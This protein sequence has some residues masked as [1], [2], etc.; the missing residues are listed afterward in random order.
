[1]AR[2][3]VR[4]AAGSLG[5]VV[6]RPD[7]LYRAWEPFTLARFFK[8]YEVELVLDIGAN[9][10]QY[11]TMIRERA[12]Y[13]GRIVSCEPNPQ[14]SD[15]LRRD[16]AG[17]AGWIIEPCAVG[18]EAGTATLKLTQNDQFSSLAA[19]TM[20]GHD[21]LKAFATVVGS[22]EVPCTT[23]DALIATH[24]KGARQGS[25]F[26]KIDTQG[27]EEHV[28]AGMRGSFELVACLQMEL[29][30]KRLYAGSWLYQEAI[31]RL[32]ELDFE[33]AALFPNNAGHFPFLVEM[34]A[35]FRN[36]R[37]PIEAELRSERHYTRRH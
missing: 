34:D 23:V 11:A 22:V 29:S 4:K 7:G 21:K 14:L 2:S 13:R 15:R 19:P 31:G 30:F 24:G 32:S 36:T 12:G 20:E 8:L 1:M 33:L 37:L 6:A 17:D 3:A 35:I 5:V 18:S 10:G 27:W 25:I 16:S 26:V 28:V 9:A